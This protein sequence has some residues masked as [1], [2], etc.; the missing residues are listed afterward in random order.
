V[1]T[2]RWT[3]HLLV[4]SSVAAGTQAHCVATRR[5]VSRHHP[6]GEPSARRPRTVAA[7]PRGFW[8]LRGAQRRRSAVWRANYVTAPTQAPTRTARLWRAMWRFGASRRR[9]GRGTRRRRQ[10]VEAVKVAT[11]RRQRHARQD[12]GR[13]EGEG[14]RVIVLPAAPAPAAIGR[15][16][17]SDAHIPDFGAGVWRNPSPTLLRRRHPV[18]RR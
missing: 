4:T 13:R 1:G 14:V 5:A 2:V 15:H 12:G 8:R 18:R 7:T 16:R 3:L 11:F 6:R 10:R 17:V 9:L